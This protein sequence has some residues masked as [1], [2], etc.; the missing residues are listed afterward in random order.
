MLLEALRAAQS[1]AMPR[2][3]SGALLLRLPPGVRWPQLGDAP[4]FV[5][6]FYRDCFE[7]PLESLKPGGRFTI[8]GNS[9]SASWAVGWWPLCGV[10]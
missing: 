2:G 8:I 9:G 3:K 7:G 4:L 5:R 1:E 10:C 6:S